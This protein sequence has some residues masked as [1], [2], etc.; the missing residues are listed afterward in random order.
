MSPGDTCDVP[1]SRQVVTSHQVVAQHETLST[2]ITI[3]SSY[4]LAEG[5]SRDT[6]AVITSYL[7]N[8]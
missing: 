4:L 2:Q 1:S 8:V 6:K 7:V 3:K 5:L